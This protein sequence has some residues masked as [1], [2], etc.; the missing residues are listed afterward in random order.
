MAMN[1]PSACHARSTMYPAACGTAVHSS[2]TD[3]PP[4]TACTPLGAAGAAPWLEVDGRMT[5]GTVMAVVAD[6]WPAAPSEL[7]AWTRYWFLPGWA[8]RSRYCVPL[9]RLRTT[10]LVPS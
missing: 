8:L 5:S 6:A 10:Q 7:K 4:A 1:G 9:T 3:P 2:V